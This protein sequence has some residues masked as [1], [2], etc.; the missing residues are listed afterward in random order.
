MQAPDL[1]DALW[2]RDEG[3]AFSNKGNA[4]YEE[5]AMA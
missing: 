2:A 5:K 3:T 1:L 4:Q